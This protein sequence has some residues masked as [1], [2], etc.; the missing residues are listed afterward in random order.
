MVILN[1]HTIVLFRHT[2][3]S[4]LGALNLEETSRARIRNSQLSTNSIAISRR[5]G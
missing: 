3:N 2:L 5:V 1:S 4:L